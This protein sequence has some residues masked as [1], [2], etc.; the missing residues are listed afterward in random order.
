MSAPITNIEQATEKVSETQQ[1]HNSSA[2][3]AS[4]IEAKSLDNEVT[5]QVSEETEESKPKGWKN[6][7]LLYIAYFVLVITAFIEAFAADS[8][9]NLDSYATSEFNA[10]SLIATAAVVYKISAICAYPI[11]AKIADLLGRGE[12]FGLSVLIYTIAYVLYS[13]CK[14]V[15]TYIC[16]E[17]FYAIGRNGYRAYQQ[18]FIADTTDLINRGLWSQ[19][20][21]A[22]TAI[23]SLYAGSYVMDAFLEHSTWRWGYGAFAIILGV[24]V[25][26]L[27]T[28]M[29]ILDHK[30]KRGANRGQAKILQ[31]LPEGSLLKKTRWVVYNELDLFGGALMLAGMALFFVPF[32]LTGKK[33]AYRWHEGKL[34]AMVVIGFVLFCC[35]LIWNTLS[36]KKHFENR[37]AFVPKQQFTNPT[38]ILVLILVALDLCENSSFATYFT[39]TLQVGGYYTAGQATR[40]DNSKKVTVDI[41]SVLAGILMKYTHRS[42]IFVLIGIPILVLGHGLLVYFMNVDGMMEK[43][44]ALYV[45]E[46]MIGFGRGF[47]QTGLQVIIQATAGVEGVAMSTA[48]FMAFNSVGSLIGS[49]IAGG[50]WN[51]VALE[52]LQKHL[53]A[54]YQ[55]N[56]TKIYSSITVAK[57]FKKGTP[58]RDAIS[59][60]YRETIQ[61]IGW[62]GLG[63][64]APMLILMFFVR[65]VHLTDKLDAYG[66][67]ESNMIRDS[68][69]SSEED[70]KDNDETNDRFAAI[71]MEKRTWTNWWRV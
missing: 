30:T 31:N 7:K 52:R 16:A 69:S 10:H 12:G 66:A 14:N 34:I 43:K 50:I 48:F 27:T 53:P 40:I 1:I 26:P 70:L 4:S 63:I 44:I 61:I 13:S 38:I 20:P 28:I 60:A 33:N 35:F 2:D 51:S 47:Y 22:L 18:I 23:P 68:A 39:T 56:A 25:I 71:N 62:T 36:G 3:S 41:A 49:A 6:K 21:G 15:Q 11:L 46:I 58:A 17:I 8:T 24:S 45:V 42:K 55:K 19:I 5:K 57:K 9:K 32:T 59:L 54:E 65:E 29:F 64:I 37:K 67:E